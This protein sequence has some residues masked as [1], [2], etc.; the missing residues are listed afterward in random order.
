LPETNRLNSLLRRPLTSFP[1]DAVKW[2]Q[3]ILLN[4][5]L[6]SMQTY[7]A[8]MQRRISAVQL[9]PSEMEK[10]AQISRP[11]KIT[12]LSEDWCID[13]LM[14]LPI[15]AQI[16]EA[17]PGMELRIFSRSKWPALKEYY[18]GRGIMAIPVYSFLDENYAEIG[19]FIERPQLAYQKMGEWKA[20]HP[21]IE[22][23]RRS[24]SISSEE[25]SSQLAKIRLILQ[26]EMEGW[27]REVC[28]SGMVAEVAGVLGLL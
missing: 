28:Q 24:A 17:T 7:Q 27:Y 5:Y 3:G 12:A 23:I 25:K 19:T 4:D 18:N 13:C 26:S 20:S 10:F 16:A 22:E 15:M 21:E 9:K 14:T 11:V 1:L 6:K 2:Q 8:D